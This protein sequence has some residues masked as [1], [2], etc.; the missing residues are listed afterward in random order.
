MN[1]I[2]DA[3]LGRLAKRLRLLGIDVLYDPA[4]TDNDIL[5]LSLEQNR[6]ILTRDTG[7][8]SRPL[9]RNHLLVKSDHVD[10]QLRQVLASLTLTDA[11]PLTRCSLCNGMLSLLDRRAAKD[12]VP[13][14]VL[15]TVNIY[16][17]CDRCG[18]IY[19]R[20]SHVR[21]WENMTQ[22]E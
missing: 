14:H 5:R 13:V 4:L 6:V 15:A 2:A 12:R 3:M 19:W 8:A 20:G 9:A 16:Y 21:N 1:F 10:D 22:K 11:A 17:Q 7:L 18:K